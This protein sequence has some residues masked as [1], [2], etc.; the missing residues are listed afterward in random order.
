[1][2]KPSPLKIWWLAASPAQKDTLSRLSKISRPQ[3]SQV[4]AGRTINPIA[5]RRVE[6]ATKKMAEKNPLPV[7]LRS[8]LCQAC[9]Q[10]E[11]APKCSFKE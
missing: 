11:F 2:K 8:Q 1:M 4:V 6:M 10:C 9:A 5:A 3:L 7:V